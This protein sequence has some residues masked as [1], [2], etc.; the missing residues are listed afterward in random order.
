MRRA[1]VL[2][3]LAA[4]APLRADAPSGWEKISDHDG[5][6]VYMRDLAGS[7]VISLRGEATVDATVANIVVTMA[8]NKTAAEWMPMV[9]ERRDLEAISATERLEL[10]HI[11]MP[12]PM[13]DRYFINRGKREDL[14]DG[15]VKLSVRSVDNPDAKY[16]DEDKVLGVLHT[17]EFLLVPVDGGQRTHITLEVNSDPKGLIPKWLVNTAQKSWPRKFFTGLASQLEKRGWLGKSAVA[18]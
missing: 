3:L 10:T 2:T 11:G 13:S 12:F 9:K 16:L 8:D 7:D 5:I 1:F 17:S 6:V 15:K 4:S 14:D 18:H